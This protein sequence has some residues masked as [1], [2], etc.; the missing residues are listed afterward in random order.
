MLA[1]EFFNEITDEMKAVAFR[2][3][4]KL[5]DAEDFHTMS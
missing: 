2:E 1:E 3:R 5:L 4:N